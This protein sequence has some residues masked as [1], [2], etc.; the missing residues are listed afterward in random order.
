MDMKKIGIVALLLVACL[1]GSAQTYKIQNA[2][3]FYTSSL[4]GMI[5]QDENGNKA[6]P[7]PT[8]GRLIYI[9]TN[10]KS[11][12]KVDSVWYNGVLFKVSIDSVKE[13]KIAA[14][15]NAATGLP[16]TITPKKS[17][18][19]WLIN[20]QQ[21]S[22]EPVLPEQVKKIVIKCRLGNTVVKQTVIREVQLSVPDA[23]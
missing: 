23:Y 6:R 15:I 5:M 3:A 12:P 9:E 17:N 22:G 1:Y 19:I 13:K 10:Y 14:G 21:A 4:P 18:Q 7:K 20:L 2:W 11:K 16:I 8:I